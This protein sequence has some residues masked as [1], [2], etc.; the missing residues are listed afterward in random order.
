M[1]KIINKPIDSLIPYINNPKQHPADQVDKIASSIKNYG[2]TVPMVIDGQN[3]IIMGHGRLQAAKK[4]GMEEVP[5]IVRDDLT[6]SQVK[7]LRIADNKV[8][9]SEWDADLL[10]MELE[11][12][13]EFTGFDDGDMLNFLD[14]GEKE[15]TDLSDS[16]SET[17]EV[18]VECRDEMQQEEVYSRLTQEGLA[19]RVLTL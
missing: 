3:E 1:N 18:I 5:C 17:Y 14:D 11:G 6:E 9:E 8:S 7:A 15:Q 16:I 4:L 12:L 19:C 13:D 2:F 10:M